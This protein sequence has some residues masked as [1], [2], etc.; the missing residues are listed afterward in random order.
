MHMRARPRS[1]AR[2]QILLQRLIE[3]SQGVEESIAPGWEISA[4]LF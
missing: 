4:G 1:M 3:V 2:A